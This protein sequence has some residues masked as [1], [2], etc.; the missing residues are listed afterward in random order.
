MTKIAFVLRLFVLG[1]ILLLQAASVRA[2]NILIDAALLESHADS[3]KLIIQEDSGKSIRHNEEWEIEFPQQFR[4][5]RL[6]Y[7]R[8]HFCKDP[9]FLELNDRKFDENG[10]YLSLSYRN[11][12][13]KT[14]HVWSDQ[15]G[16]EK[17]ATVGSKQNLNRNVFYGIQ[18][19]AGGF[20]IDRVRIKNKGR[21]KTE[22]AV[23]QVHYLEFF[24]VEEP[25]QDETYSR[26]FSANPMGDYK[27]R[28]DIDNVAGLPMYQNESWCFNLPESM[29]GRQINYIVIKFRQSSEKIASDTYFDENPASILVQARDRNTGHIWPWYDR[30]GREKYVEPRTADDPETECLHDCLSCMKNVQPDRIIL[31]HIGSGDREKSIALLYSVEVIVFP[32]IARTSISELIFTA[33]T[34]FSDPAAGLDFPAYGGGPRFGGKYPGA[35][36]IG[37]RRHFRRIYQNAIHLMH[38]FATSEPLPQDG[39]IDALGRLNLNLPAGKKLRQ[40]EI[41]AGD[42]DNTILS[43]N[44]DKHFGRLGWSE[45]YAYIRSGSDMKLRLIADKAN[46]GPEGVIVF[47]PDS[48]DIDIFPGDQLVIE[49]RLDVAYLMGI[50]LMFLLGV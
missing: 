16:S 18:S 2:D 23:A 50:R 31:K 14:W 34:S 20:P 8:M 48:G 9:K 38:R 7:V 26:V 28:F 42:V 24:F 12:D 49:S 43:H 32:D 47:L 15:F 41:A 33:D 25:R 30:Y 27:V 46:V 35:L 44:K 19:M 13:K 45:L 6:N 22:L 3:C 37:V 29:A 21:G 40:V 11:A 1:L 5:R 39:Y 4:N 10:A 36:M 17:F